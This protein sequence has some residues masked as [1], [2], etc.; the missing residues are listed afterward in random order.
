M[1]LL[2]PLKGENTVC[3]AVAWSV[4]VGEVVEGPQPLRRG[5]FGGETRDRCKCSVV[6]LARASFLPE[7]YLSIY[8]CSTVKYPYFSYPR[9]PRRTVV[10]THCSTLESRAPPRSPYAL[11]TLTA[12]SRAFQQERGGR[13][14]Y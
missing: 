6:V 4:V 7:I 10:F 9:E 3:D 14:P 1:V 12:V 5:L 8:L 13:V 2:C 11:R